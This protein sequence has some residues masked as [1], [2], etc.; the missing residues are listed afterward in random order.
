MFGAKPRRAGFTASN[1][2]RSTSTITGNSAAMRCLHDP[3]LLR[4]RSR[5]ED[6]LLRGKSRIVA[7]VAPARDVR[8]VRR[9]VGADPRLRRFGVEPAVPAAD[10]QIE[11][12][13]VEHAA[14][15]RRRVEQA[16]RRAVQRRID[17]DRAQIRLDQRRHAL[18]DVLRE[19]ERNACSD[20]PAG[21]QRAGARRIVGQRLI[22]AIVLRKERRYLGRRK[23][24]LAM[25]DRLCDR[26]AIDRVG[27][28][29]AHVHVGK[30]FGLQFDAVDV[31]ARNRHERDARARLALAQLDRR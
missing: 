12:A 2:V 1:S 16:R 24:A 11:L 6:A 9:A 4:A 22:D 18:I 15:G 5:I 14:L 3:E 31:I 23:R 10:L 19:I 21:E 26:R 7:R 28:R 20:V 17:A 13:V 25:V 27:N 29:P 8:P 30:M